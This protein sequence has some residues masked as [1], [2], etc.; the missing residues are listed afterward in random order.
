MLEKSAAAAILESQRRPTRLSGIPVLNAELNGG[1]CS[2]EESRKANA[3]ILVAVDNQVAGESPPRL[4]ALGIHAGEVDV[5]KQVGDISKSGYH[6]II[7]SPACEIKRDTFSSI[8]SSWQTT[9]AD[10]CC[11]Q[12]KSITEI[13][14]AKPTIAFGTCDCSQRAPIQSGTLQNCE[15]F[16]KKCIVCGHYCGRPAMLDLF[17]G[18]GGA[19][20]GYRIAGFCVLGVDHKPMPRYAGCRFVQADALEFLAAHGSKFDVIHASPPCQKYSQV[21]R[22]QHLQGYDYPDLIGS[23]RELLRGKGRLWVIENVEASPLRPAIRLCGT[24]FGLPVRRHR[25]FESSVMLFSVPCNHTRF[26]DKKYPT[27]FQTKGA[28]RRMSSVVQC[29]GNT[30]GV[31]LWPA[32]LGIDWMTR[33]EMSQ[34]IPPAYTEWIGR[35]LIGRLL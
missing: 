27:C 3:A 5:Q 29:Y 35:Q 31:G 22:R 34:A 2:E 4:K 7:P 21:N 12:K 30:S 9:S 17:S 6:L 8:G 33:Y 19:A 20:Y 11:Q 14:S 32:A 23:T 10:L 1:F 16:A 24:S 13:L 18:A 25:L 26:R 15:S 28:R